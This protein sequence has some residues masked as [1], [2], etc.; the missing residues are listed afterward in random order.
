MREQG[1]DNDSPTTGHYGVAPQ[2]I[3]NSVSN[4]EGIIVLTVKNGEPE[5]WTDKSERDAQ[6]LLSQF[7]PSAVLPKMEPVG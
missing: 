4:A 3:F 5:L 7:F 2:Q 1:R 6:Q